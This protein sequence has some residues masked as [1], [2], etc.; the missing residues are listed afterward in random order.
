MLLETITDPSLDRTDPDV[1][2]GRLVAIELAGEAGVMNDAMALALINLAR[3]PEEDPPARERAA[4]SLGPILEYVDTEGFDDLLADVGLPGEDDLPIS[5]TVLHR[6][7]DE[8]RA[9]YMDGQ[10]PKDVRR[11]ALE[12]SIRAPRGWHRDAVRAAYFSG[13]ED[14]LMTAVFAMHWVQGF[15]EQIMEALGSDDDR[16]RLLALHAAG[17][18][19]VARAWPVVSEILRDERDDKELLLT[20][21]EAAPGVNAAGAAMLLASL[22]DSPDQEIAEAALEAITL[23]KGLALDGDDAG[24]AQELL[25]LVEPDDDL[26]DLDDELSEG[27]LDDLYAVA[28]TDDDDD[29]D[30]D[31]DGDGGAE[32]EVVDIE[33]SRGIDAGRDRDGRGPDASG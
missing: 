33:T 27:L 26:D 8:L 22:A 19:E 31:D 17:G 7:Q 9:V 11:S 10:A 21:I 15:D 4:L 16:V 2:E 24:A 5:E 13:D 1:Q 28:D 12:A 18:S 29:D 32:G 25:K 6:I 30:D 14:W 23:A 20:A 3:D